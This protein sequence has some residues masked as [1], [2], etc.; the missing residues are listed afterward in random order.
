MAGVILLAGQTVSAFFW[1]VRSVL[2]M[3]GKE[4]H[5]MRILFMSAGFNVVLNFMLIPIYGT[6]GA[7]VATAVSTTLV[8]TL[9]WRAA[10]KTI[11]INSSLLGLIWGRKE[12]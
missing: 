5:N 12:K 11:S 1:A 6:I 10:M 2:T 9:M 8:N 4:N 7:A 3:C